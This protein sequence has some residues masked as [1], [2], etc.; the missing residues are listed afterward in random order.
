MMRCMTTVGFAFLRKN[1]LPDCF[2]CGWAQTIFWTIILKFKQR[3][4]IFY[5]P[6]K[7]IRFLS[8]YFS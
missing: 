8:T 2:D 1:L 6:T 5:K 3:Y 7:N 4:Y